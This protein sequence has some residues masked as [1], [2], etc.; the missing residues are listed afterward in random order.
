M[1]VDETLQLIALGHSN[2]ILQ[3]I[4][5]EITRERCFVVTYCLLLPLSS[6]RAIRSGKRFILHN[7]SEPVTGLGICD[8]PAEATSS[9]GRTRAEGLSTDC[10]SPIVFAS[11][12]ACTMSFVL[13]RRDEIQLQNIL[14]QHREGCSC[15]TMIN[16]N[17]ITPVT[18]FVVADSQ[19]VRFYNWDGRSRCLA[20][21]GNKLAVKEFK[22][23]LVIVRGSKNSYLSVSSSNDTH[24]V[25]ASGESVDPG[26]SGTVIIHDYLNHFIAGEFPV[27]DIVSL[28]VEWDAIYALCEHLGSSPRYSLVCISEKSTQ[29]KL[30]LLF[31][32]K[33]FQLA[34][35][36]AK[37]QNLSREDTTH[38]IWRYADHLYKQKE[39]DASIKEYVK[40]IGVLEPSFV[41][42]RFLEGGHITQLA[43]YLEALNESSVATSDH[44]ILLL[45]CYSRLQDKA[46]INQFVE[47][48]VNQN[49]D[50]PTAI[51]VLRQSGCPAAALQLARA[52]GHSS[53]EVAILV[54]DLEDGLEAL[55]TIGSFPFDEALKAVCTHGPLLMERYPKETVTVLE[56]LC[57]HPEASR[58]NIHH[59]LQIF[60]NNGEGLLRFLQRYVENVKVSEKVAG[61]T[62]T[63]LELALHEAEK[64]DKT[65]GNVSGPVDPSVEKQRQNLLELAK[66]L[67]QSNQEL[68]IAH[69]SGQS[70]SDN[71]S[72][73]RTKDMKFCSIH[74]FYSVISSCFRDEMPNLWLLALRYFA[75]KPENSDELQQVI[76]EVDR[77]ELT[78]PLL[79][80]QILSDADTNQSC[81]I[82]AIRR[83][84]LLRHLESGTDKINATAPRS[85]KTQVT[86]RRQMTES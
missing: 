25:P 67:L 22:Q 62:D 31:S 7:F 2:G 45:N 18:H 53:S 4:K 66:R 42:Q 14:D 30:E 8:A 38:I 35:D 19:A 74:H 27:P 32:K 24:I 48:P 84:Y 21:G 9:V 3:V 16:E 61:V 11:T 77:H 59:L 64:L 44:L 1:S 37:S 73:K 50:I 83:H 43:H 26:D 12:N 65:N 40:T 56:D 80:L 39:Y 34:L 85:S 47:G 72:V 70:I 33:N 78:P 54:E 57:A 5:G 69:P 60:I 68:P 58:I 79:M 10:V 76:S 6:V 75:G 29:A 36:V 51:H 49:L 28:F 20:T 13:G 52:K 63:L 41:I 15:S 71:E 55:K 46:K 82:G 23:Y 17:S 86:H 81:S